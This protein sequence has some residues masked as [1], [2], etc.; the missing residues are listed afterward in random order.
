MTI[1][2]TI[3]NSL[4]AV[5]ASLAPALGKVVRATAAEIE[6]SAKLSLS[7]AKSGR[8][9]KRRGISHQASAPGEAPATDTGLLANSI[10]TTNDGALTAIVGVGAEYAEALE[11]GTTRMGPRPFLTPAAE[12]A[13][14]GFDAAVADILK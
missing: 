3:S 5:S 4:P 1:K 14:R 9:Y 10:N 6:S 8:V 7:G 11:Y 2:V 13:R 12:A